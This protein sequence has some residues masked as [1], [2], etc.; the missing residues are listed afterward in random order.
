M[1]IPF[2]DLS[3]PENIVKEVF[4]D[5]RWVKDEFSNRLATEILEFSKSL[6][7]SFPLL[8]SLNKLAENSIQS[9]LVTGFIQ[10]VLDDLVVSTKLLITG[11]LM[12][13]GNLMRQAIEG[14]CVA[15]L[16]GANRPLAIQQET[17]VY[18]K[19]IERSDPSVMGHKAV[20]QVEKNRETLGV[21]EDAV[22]RLRRAKEHYDQFSHPGLLGIASRVTLGEVGT[23]FIGGTFDE[24][25]LEAYRTEL[26]ER[27]GFCRLLP[28]VIQKLTM[29]CQETSGK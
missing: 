25:K 8:L 17:L 18:W 10:G 6:A 14:L 16:C 28:N 29:Q 5:D 9:S 1:E 15:I 11:K 13:S 27:I 23:V 3:K 24:E 7:P 26:L 20:R 4:D 19:S 21:T 22:S 2:V 12:A